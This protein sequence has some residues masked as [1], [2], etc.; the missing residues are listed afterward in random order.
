MLYWSELEVLMISLI[1]SVGEKSELGKDGGLAF[2]GKG[3]LGYFKNTTMGHKVLMGSKTFESLPRRLEGR[4]Y[5]VASRTK[6]G[7]PE[8]VNVVTDLDGFLKEW[9]DAEEEI[10]VIGGGSIY[11][12]ALPR[13]NRLYLTEVA[14]SC[15]GADVFFPEFDKNQYTREKVGEGEYDD[16]LAFARFVYSKK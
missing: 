7:F 10:F 16:G 3:E 5:F 11:A 8:W 14:G 6:D 1:A 13:A 12:Y 15:D 4:E 2:Q 9:K